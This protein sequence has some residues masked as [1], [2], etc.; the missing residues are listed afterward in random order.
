MAAPRRS[1]NSI[2]SRLTRTNLLVNNLAAAR[3]AGLTLSSDLL[4]LAV[5]IRRAP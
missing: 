1:R 3:R 2:Q 5:A 4:K